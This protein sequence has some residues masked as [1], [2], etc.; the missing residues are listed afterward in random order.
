MGHSPLFSSSPDSLCSLPLLHL[1]LSLLLGSIL[2]HALAD[3]LVV[4]SNVVQEP[5]QP[6]LNGLVHLL[7]VAND[8]RARLL[9]CEWQ[10]LNSIFD[11]DMPSISVKIWPWHHILFKITQPTSQKIHVRSQKS[12]LTIWQRHLFSFTSF[13]RDR[14]SMMSASANAP[15]LSCLLASLR[16]EKTTMPWFCNYQCGAQTGQ[17]VTQPKTQ[18]SWFESGNWWTNWRSRLSEDYLTVYPT[19][20][21]P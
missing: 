13:S 3:T 19:Q 18:V 10:C 15:S 12:T 14:C 1:L 8:S 17:I 11:N 9:Q 20:H 21:I 7:P 16:E 5:V 6:I 4:P 2:L